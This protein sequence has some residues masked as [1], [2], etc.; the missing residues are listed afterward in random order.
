MQQ[1]KIE[2]LPTIVVVRDGKEAARMLGGEDV[3]KVIESLRGLIQ[4]VKTA[5]STM[6]SMGPE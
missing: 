1:Y 5:G 3:G 4:E 2:K 6:G